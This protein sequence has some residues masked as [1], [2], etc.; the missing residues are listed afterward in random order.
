[1]RELKPQIIMGFKKRTG[2]ERELR[3]FVKGCR[4]RRVGRAVRDTT[5]QSWSCRG[6][7]AVKG[8]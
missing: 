8:P 1:M 7:W 2:L 4:R 6:S 5:Q 3:N